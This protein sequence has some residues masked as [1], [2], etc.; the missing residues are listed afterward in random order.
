MT[1]QEY[2]DLDEAQRK[3]FNSLPFENRK[4]FVD[5]SIHNHI[6][7]LEQ[8]KDKVVRAHKK[9]MADYNDQIRNLKKELERVR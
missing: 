8:C 3:A 4:L 5:H 9:L 7:H 2:K 6:L 1:S